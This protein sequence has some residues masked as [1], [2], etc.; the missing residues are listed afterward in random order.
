MPPHKI[1][2]TLKLV[3]VPKWMLMAGARHGDV[4]TV[5]S[6]GYFHGGG[7]RTDVRFWRDPTKLRSLLPKRLEVVEN[8]PAV[9]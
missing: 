3:D 4:G 2:Q 8:E 1:G 7:H 6:V 5:E 9:A